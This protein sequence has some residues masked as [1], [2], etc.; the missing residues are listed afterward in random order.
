MHLTT[1]LTRLAYITST[2][3]L[4]APTA[5]VAANSATIAV[6][7]DGPWQGNDNILKLYEK[8]IRNLTEGEWTLEFPASKRVVADWSASGVAKAL[9]T[10]L[11]D[12]EVDLV[13]AL[14]II[15]ADNAGKRKN[16]A[17]PVVA[18]YVIDAR[19]QGLPLDPKLGSSGKKNFTYVTNPSVLGN[20]L[21]A[22]NELTQATKV[23]FMV[24]EGFLTAVP[25]LGPNA[26]KLAKA[27][28]I[29]LT[30]VRVQASAA[31]A[32][33]AIPVDA[34]AVYVGAQLQLGAAETKLLY[35]GLID[36]HLPSF[37]QLGR[38]EVKAGL[39]AAIGPGVNNPRRVRRV[40]LN[41]QAILS[42]E[43]ASRM[44]VI[45]SRQER[46]VIN[47]A[48]ARA[49]PFWPSFAALT[50]ADL[51]KP[52]VSTD[53]E[54]MTL[55]GA[56][57]DA[58][59]QNL[60]L[61]ANAQSVAASAENIG[62]A[63]AN[64]LPQI[65]LSASAAVIDSDRASVFANRAQRQLSASGVLTQ[66]LYSEKA[67]ANLKI[68]KHLQNSRVLQRETLSLDI[69]RDTMVAYLNVLRARTFERIQRGNLS[70]TRSNL[71][72]AQVRRTIGSAGP[73]EVFRW[74]SQ[75]AND[76]GS[77]ISAIAQRNA[78]EIALNR[79]LNR[80]LE[81][82]VLMAEASLDDPLQML[83]KPDVYEEFANP[84]SFRIFRS[85]MVQEGLQA[86]PELSTVDALIAARERRV[87][88]SRRAWWLP[89]FGLQA[90]V[91]QVVAQGGAASEAVDP[92]QVAPG[93]V[94]P[95]D[96]SWSLGLSAQV[97][98]FSGLGRHA[99]QNQADHELTQIRTERRALAQ[100][101]EQGIRT[102]IHIAGASFANIRQSRL[103]ATAAEKNLEVVRDNYAQGGLNY[104]NLLDAQNVA[105]VS[106]R[107]A[108]S[109]AYSFLIDRV[110]VQRRVSRFDLLNSAQD[111][112]AW[113][114]RLQ[115][116]LQEQGHASK[117]ARELESTTK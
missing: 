44:K 94:I 47:M 24:S 54:T 57:Q 27:E 107:G 21:R 30:L 5:A 51:I 22:L 40:A 75:L 104:L 98:L 29:D 38:R 69:V 68:Q 34:Q 2:L 95:N 111:N 18:P 73:S 84:W 41:V 88:A 59:A 10:V 112:K 80:P 58:I 74:R 62:L 32:L 37:A 108:A 4:I 103:S 52:G 33:K 70:L 56:T 72:L 11:A 45:V 67:Y 116:F 93:Q 15:A 19:I 89:T 39:L 13:L 102:A 117:S 36:R 71:E 9:D 8:E 113:A 91:D 64:I 6:V 43:D 7:I 99:E 28:G 25:D 65:D 63:R 48:T 31:P 49:I 87:T 97:P 1:Y 26:I 20:D 105:L 114:Q 60:D 78:T 23:A 106:R 50:E 110:E 82:P 35:Q 85:F 3:L 14:G 16:L 96:T 66:T 109:A 92:S 55:A 46:L 17:K 101:V 53:A 77:V 86:A 90:Q 81:A 115:A 79:L 42:G 61:R 100:R 83:Q 12:P 76:R